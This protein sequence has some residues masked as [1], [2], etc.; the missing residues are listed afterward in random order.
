MGFLNPYLM[1]IKIAIL[2]IAFGVGFY[3]GYKIESASKEAL[4]ASYKEAQ[5]QA[6]KAALAKQQAEDNLKTREALDAAL[7]Q[8]KLTQQ[9]QDRLNEV[10]KAL[11]NATVHCITN[12]VVELLNRASGATTKMPDTSR[13]PL[14]ACST[15]TAN[16]LMRNVI[17]NY[18]IALK[19]A[20]QLDDLIHSIHELNH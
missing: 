7:H 3:G 14:D 2:V 10:D 8:Q 12:G 4:I 18:G 6:L 17:S 9:T 11:K 1:Y 19:N 13:L 16:Q 20:K 15:V 5:V